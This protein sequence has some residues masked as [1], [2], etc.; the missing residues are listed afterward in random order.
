VRAAPC[1]RRIERWIRTDLALGI[2]L[3]VATV[4]A[5]LALA[6]LLLA[7]LPNRA[8]RWI[9]LLPGAIVTTAGLLTL[10]VFT[11]VWLRASWRRCRKPTAPSVW[12][13]P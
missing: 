7:F 10:N 6:L 8:S 3:R 13:W 4:A 5:H 1:D 12:R 9:D 11:V 2:V